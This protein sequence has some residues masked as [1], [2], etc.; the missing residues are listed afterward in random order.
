MKFNNLLTTTIFNYLFQKT[1]NLNL[2]P[3]Y[4]FVVNDV[5]PNR[6]AIVA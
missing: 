3:I 2:H 1:S 5:H 6:D 4:S